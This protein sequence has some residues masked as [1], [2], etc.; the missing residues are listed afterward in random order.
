MSKSDVKVSDEFQALT[1]LMYLDGTPRPD[2]LRVPKTPSKRTP[3]SRFLR[4]SKA[5][6]SEPQALQ[7][8]VSAPAPVSNL[9]LEPNEQ[10]SEAVH[11]TKEEKIEEEATGDALVSTPDIGETVGDQVSEEPQQLKA[12]GKESSFTSGNTRETP[13]APPLAAS[14]LPPPD[15]SKEQRKSKRTFSVQ[16][17]SVVQSEVSLLV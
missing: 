11:S 13:V 14:S 3:W 17:N 12:D 4:R 8:P 16:R 1:S 2:E 7:A 6:H 9:S 10:V 5:S 15:K